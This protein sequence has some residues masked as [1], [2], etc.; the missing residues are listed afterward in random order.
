MLNDLPWVQKS[1]YKHNILLCQVQQTVSWGSE[2]LMRAA[3]QQLTKY[4][5]ARRYH[6][7][8]TGDCRQ[9]HVLPWN[10]LMISDQTKTSFQ[11]R[12]HFL[13]VAGVSLYFS[14]WSIKLEYLG[15]RPRHQHFLQTPHE[16]LI[17]LHRSESLIGKLA[18][19]F[20]SP[21]SQQKFL[22]QPERTSH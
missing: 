2:S 12:A 3:T 4:T 21:T 6:S 20:S 10:S 13:F 17:C 5:Q 9:T 15:V 18:S 22:P 19:I 11:S 1:K 16:I 8:L 7:L 14:T